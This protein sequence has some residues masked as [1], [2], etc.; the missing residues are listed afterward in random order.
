[1]QGLELHPVA[2]R[3]IVVERGPAAGLEGRGHHHV[4]V[5]KGLRQRYALGPPDRDAVQPQ[6]WK[7][8]LPKAA[9]RE[10]LTIQF[11]ESLDHALAQRMIH[12]ADKSAH[13]VD[14]KVA[15]SDHE[16]RWSFVPAQPWNTGAHTLLVQNTIED[17]AGNNIGKSFE[18]DLFEGVQRRF[19]NTTVRLPFEVK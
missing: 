17:T 2:G 4:V 9:T 6:R 7:L 14:G 8:Q 13:A 10:P 19:T 1:M 5:H 3:Q 15:I 18:V 16:R 11:G 12:V